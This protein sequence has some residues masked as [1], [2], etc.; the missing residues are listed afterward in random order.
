M[1]TLA[2]DRLTVE[3]ER[4]RCF[5]G[6]AG[7]VGAFRA[8]PD[9]VDHGAVAMLQTG[10][11]LPALDGHSPLIALWADKTWLPRLVT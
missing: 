5:R 4:V 10:R 8:V 11:A 7:V 3:A 9:V 6:G 2:A 1:G